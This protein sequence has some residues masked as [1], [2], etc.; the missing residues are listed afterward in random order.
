MHNIPDSK[1]IT[2]QKNM[3]SIIGAGPA[4]C[5]TAYLLAKAGK[6]VQVFEEHS[7]IGKPVQCTGIL[8]AE[9]AKILKPEELQQ[10]LMNKLE[11]ARIYAPDNSFFEFKTKEYVVDRSKFDT[12]LAEKARTAGAI[13]HLKTRI[14]K[15]QQKKGQL[16]LKTKNKEFSTNQ[17]IGADG[18]NSIVS[19]Y[20]G[21]S[22]PECWL[23]IQATAQGR[24]D[25]KTYHVYFGS[26]HSDFFAWLVP[27]SDTTARIG[28]ASNKNPKDQFNRFIKR[29]NVKTKEIQAGLIPKFNKRIISETDK[30]TNQNRIFLVGDAATQV[31]ATTG[32][33]IVPGLKAAQHLA[34]AIINDSDYG[35]GKY[36]WKKTIGKELRVHSLARRMVDRFSDQDFNSLIK[37]MNNERIKNILQKTDRDNAS[38]AIFKSVL[39]RP[40]LLKY[41][42]ILLRP[43]F[44]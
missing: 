31:K 15:I 21:N 1:A 4:G 38:K 32:G 29:F 33:G 24:F 2:N 35:Y 44:R 40:S 7:E 28:L 26:D 5:Y 34:E 37:D 41:V 16:L 39:A 27:E 12:F 42:R 36:C 9:I 19:R 6:K 14:D 11:K 20:L 8:T 18:P 25:P 23:G 22:K 13:F 10:S 30:K 3:I 43:R 17:L